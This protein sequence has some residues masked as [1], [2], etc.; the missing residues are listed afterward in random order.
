MR[1]LR[2]TPPRFAVGLFFCLISLS[3]NVSAG[4]ALI[5]SAGAEPSNLL[6]L[7]ASDSASAQVSGLLYNG[8]VKYDKDLKLTGDLA[9]DWEIKDGGLR[10]IF[11]LRKGVVWHDGAPFTAEDV[12]FTFRKLTD[13]AL[14]TPYGGDFEKVSSL[15][16]LDPHTVEVLYKEP[17]SP[18]LA[19]WVMGI[20]PKHAL[21]NE[22]L[23]STPF[24]RAPIGTGP[25]R[26]KKW[27]SGEYLELKAN[28]R[29]FEGA[30]G[31][32]RIV[33]RVIPDQATA[34]LELQTETID[35]SGLTPLQFEKQ[36]D[37][38]F[39]KRHYRKF[40]LPSF[41]YT[42]LGYNLENPFFSD[43]RTRRAIG[44]AID[45][46]EII[47][48][49]L[50]GKGRVATGPF[51]P[52]TWA[53]NEDVKASAFDPERAR[54]L[55]SEAGWR[56]TDG[57][58]ILDREGLKFSFMLLTNHGT[59]ERKTACEII[60]KRLKD[61]GVRVEIR[62]V[63]WRTFL[64]EFIDKRKFDAVLL[65]WQLSRD[66]DIF[67][68]FHSSKTAE[69]QFNFVSYKNAEVDRLLEEGR[70]I[71]AEE[72]RAKVYRRLHEILSRDEAYTFLYVPESLLALHGRFEGAEPSPAGLMHDLVHWR[73]PEDQRKYDV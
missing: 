51:L 2:S 55:L 57:D 31:I 47:Q 56:D 72:E 61:V 16:V 66:P 48:A 9:S 46:R 32:A 58:G 10:I 44:L 27:K 42:Y 18:G 41:G 68:M 60:Q 35:L 45:K 34:F 21:Q 6:P 5:T 3:S 14:P 26:L 50:L 1:L 11:H 7:F 65:A 8:L 59:D 49:V 33:V 25:Y 71:F 73:V 15:K 40:S 29:Y 19:S 36:T 43:V 22:D 70:R 53:Y 69:G 30:P 62:V 64:K 4:D 52:R 54:R 63:E 28:D 24:A 17:F 67:D 20:L 23:M 39:F 38:V 13:P 37:T 12:D